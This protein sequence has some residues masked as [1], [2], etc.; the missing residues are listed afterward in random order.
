MAAFLLF[1]LA[2]GPGSS[3]ADENYPKY[4][5]TC[6]YNQGNGDSYTGSV[7]VA[8]GDTRFSV[9]YTQSVSEEN[10]QTGYYIITGE[11][12]FAG[13]SGLPGQVYVSSYDDSESQ[14]TFTP[15]HS[16]TALGTNY[17]DSKTGYISKTGI[18]DFK[19][20]PGTDGIFYEADMD[21]WINLVCIAGA[22]KGINDKSQ[23]VGSTKDYT[24]LYDNGTL[25]VLDTPLQ[26]F[27]S[28]QRAAR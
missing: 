27:R 24:F 2:L 15:V 28:H 20:D 7:Y 22:A 17:L 10:G 1:S 23:A 5:F 4:D 26:R 25:T 14:T 6:C 18:T 21:G 9:G 13:A 16:S 3:W 19:F 11:T 12:D 8:A